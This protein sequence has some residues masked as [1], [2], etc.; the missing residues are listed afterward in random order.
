MNSGEKP[1]FLGNWVFK[2]NDWTFPRIMHAQ[3]KKKKKDNRKRI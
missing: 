2:D 3:K 1:L